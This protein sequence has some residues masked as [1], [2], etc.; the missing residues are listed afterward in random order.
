MDA[1]VSLM[2]W[3]IYEERSGY[4][5][6]ESVTRGEK[7]LLEEIRGY[8]RTWNKIRNTVTSEDRLKEKRIGY[9]RRGNKM[10]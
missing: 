9:K 1:L 10:H 6:R 2:D 8:K 7:R 5:R 4:R 3:C